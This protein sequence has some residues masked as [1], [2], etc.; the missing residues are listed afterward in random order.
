[1]S[2]RY[3]DIINLP[4]HTSKTR[5]R[6]SMRDRAA[7]FAP[8]AALT[9]YDAAVREAARLTNERIELDEYFKSLI[10]ERLCILRDCASEKTEVSITYF[11]PDKKKTGGA[12]VTACGE[13]CKIDEHKRELVLLDGT[14]IPIDEILDIS[15]EVFDVL[16]LD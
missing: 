6:M 3:Y 10:N 5:R 7:Q 2:S 13:V 14:K 1:M 12:Y 11:V 4:H 15:G 16:E 9:G 8:F